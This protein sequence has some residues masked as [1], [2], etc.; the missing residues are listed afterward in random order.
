MLVRIIN[1][2]VFVKFEA[3]S[4]TSP[5]IHWDTTIESSRPLNCFHHRWATTLTRHRATHL[6]SKLAQPLRLGACMWECMRL[7]GFHQ[8][9][10]SSRAQDYNVS[11]VHHGRSCI[12]TETL[13][14]SSASFLVYLRRSPISKRTV[15]RTSH[16]RYRSAGPSYTNTPPLVS[17]TTMC[18]VTLERRNRHGV[19]K[20]DQ[21]FTRCPGT[22]LSRAL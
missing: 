5:R 4:I 19:E 16:S 7:D 17:F 15:V 3:P 22:G 21:A 20:L 8:P 9:A 1:C 13:Q 10:H 6:A 12:S 14:L 11:N 2:S 18:R